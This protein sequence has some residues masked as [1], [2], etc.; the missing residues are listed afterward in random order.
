MNGDGNGVGGE[1]GDGDG[2]GEGDGAGTRT[3]VEAS[4][5]KQDGNNVDEGG[6]SWTNK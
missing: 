5:E 6:D 2:G 4:E 1:N 3:G